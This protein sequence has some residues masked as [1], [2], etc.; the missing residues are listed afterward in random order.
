MTA[1]FNAL[2]HLNAIRAFDAVLRLGS[3]QAAA[4]EL[5]V[6]DGAVSRHIKQL[7]AAIGMPL[8]RREHRKLTPTELGLRMGDDI[9]AGLHRIG[10]ASAKVAS[11][12]D[13]AQLVIAAPATFLSRWMIPRQASLQKAIGDRPVLFTTYHG[14]P[15]MAPTQ[16]HLFIGVGPVTQLPGYAYAPFMSQTL[17][18]IVEA[19]M[20][21]KLRA[22]PDW[23]RK[24]TRFTPASF[25]NLW[26]VWAAQYGTSAIK[27]DG[28]EVTLERMNYAIEAVEAGHGYTVVPKQFVQSALTAGRLALAFEGRQN[29]EVFG[30]HVPPRYAQSLAVEKTVSWLRAEGGR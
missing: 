19:H 17:C 26:Q 4:A 5:C 30:V 21:R 24:L 10:Q 11:A 16:V 22:D 29:Q 25:P 9:R 6:T 3:V 28:P 15:T 20:L 27:F 7:E 23:P 12:N 14:P 8:F 13:A 18:V 2:Q 1:S